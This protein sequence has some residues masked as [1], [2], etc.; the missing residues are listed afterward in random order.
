MKKILII[1]ILAILV[2]CSPKAI[3]YQNHPLPPAYFPKRCYVHLGDIKLIDIQLS[4]R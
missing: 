2:G 4:R 1:G 3:G